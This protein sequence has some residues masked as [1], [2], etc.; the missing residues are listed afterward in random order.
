MP[1][2]ETIVLDV[3]LLI[4]LPA[5]VG[6]L[7][8]RWAGDT[9]RRR[10]W[11]PLRVRI[12]RIVITVGWIAVVIAD[13]AGTVGTFS[14]LSALTVSAVAGIA[15]TLALQTTLQ[16]ILSGF[17]L[18]QQRF[19]HLGDQIQF[20]GIKGTVVSI[21]LVEVVLKTDAGALA[22]VSNANLLAGPMVNFTAAQRLS[23]EY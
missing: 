13:T 11:P 9:A 16:N 10:G 5:V 3:L 7:L 17:I 8:A 23:G 18:I 22:M 19:L 15:V 1:S 6:Y 12:L 2:T 20:S 21:G 4:V 14:F